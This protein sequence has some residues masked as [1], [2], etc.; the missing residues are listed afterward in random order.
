M[1]RSYVTHTTQNYESITINL[2]ESIKK[3]SE[4]PILVYT[5]DYDASPYLKSIAE[6]KRL[7]LN[8]PVETEDDFFN[9]DGNLYVNRGTIRTFLTLSSKV[10]VLLDVCDTDIDEWVYLDSDCILNLNGDDLFDF[11]PQIKEVPLATKGPHQFVLVTKN[12][13]IIGNPFWK[14]DGSVD[15]ES[16][17]E[18]PLMKFFGMSPNER[19]NY[20]TTNIIFGKF[21]L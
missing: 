6:C 12:D 19:I 11:Q 14:G 4:Y 15:L 9:K 3:Y 17:L 1:K 2:V 21:E 16:T 7:D 8:L 20:H 18:Y 5:I 10:D 13:E